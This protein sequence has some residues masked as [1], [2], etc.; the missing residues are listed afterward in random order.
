[1]FPSARRGAAGV[2]VAALMYLFGGSDR[3]NK[4]L[5]D[6]WKVTPDGEWT[7]VPH[8]GNVPS[9]RRL[10]ALSGYGTQLFLFGGRDSSDEPL[11]DLWV[12]SISRSVWTDFSVTSV[13]TS[14]TIPSARA[15]HSLTL[16]NRKLYLFGGETE[17]GK[18]NELWV[19]TRARTHGPG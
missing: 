7:L 12:F 8:V 14:G 3:S 13:T 6:L 5:S 1:M 2:R 18:S 15:G 19:I 4:V 11:S 9:A 17:S 16:L 10:G